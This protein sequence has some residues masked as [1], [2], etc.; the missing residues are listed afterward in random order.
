[1]DAAGDRDRRLDA[2][3]QSRCAAEA[4]RQL[5]GIRQRQRANHLELVDVDVDAV[6]AREQHEPVGAG[7]VELL[8]EMREGGEE[9][10]EL[11]GDRNAQL[12]FTSRTISIA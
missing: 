1:M 11:D 6:E 9:R 3:G 10:R 7:R 2:P 5:R 4:Q 12:R 8:G